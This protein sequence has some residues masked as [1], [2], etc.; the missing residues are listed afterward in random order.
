MK[1]IVLFGDS[2]FFGVGASSRELGCGKLLKKMI[3]VPV[4]IKGKSLD[5]SRDALLKLK[6]NTIIDY[7]NAEYIIIM[8]GN[9]DCRLIGINKP[10]TCL[11]EFRDNLRQIIEEIRKNKVVPILTNLQPIDNERIM[12]NMNETQ[13]FYVLATQ[14]LTEDTPY[15]WQKKYSDVCESVAVS[16]QVK[17]I[18]IRTPLCSHREK[19]IA[20]D[21]LHP[22]DLGHKVISVAISNFYKSLVTYG[23]IS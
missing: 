22:N 5:T 15:T 23:E 21:G 7:N 3:S 19:Y 13:L 12:R 2:V 8:F 1:G 14:S 16:E 11:D 6:K 10:Q 18:D 9:N 4:I 17:L 20:A